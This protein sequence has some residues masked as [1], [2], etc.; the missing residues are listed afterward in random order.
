MANLK[1]MGFPTDVPPSLGLVGEARFRGFL[2]QIAVLTAVSVHLVVSAPRF[3]ES[4]SVMRKP[5]KTF[6]LT[7]SDWLN[8]CCVSRAESDYDP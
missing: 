8:S 7:F 5:E 3:L 6:P 1:G 4:Y 2:E